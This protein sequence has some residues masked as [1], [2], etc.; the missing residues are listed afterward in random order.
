VGFSDCTF[1]Q[2]G[3]GGDQA[4]I[5]AS[6]GN[7]LVRGCEFLENKPHILLGENVDC[8]VISG[9]LFTG[10]AQIRNNSQKDVQIG[11]NSASA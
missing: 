3:N 6:S 5:Q 10:S 9:N 2:W 11:L 4:A 1:V 8:A 7:V